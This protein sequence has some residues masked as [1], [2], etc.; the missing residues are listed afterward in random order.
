MTAWAIS[1]EQPPSWARGGSWCSPT[2]CLILPFCS[3][4]ACLLDHLAATRACSQ[5]SVTGRGMQEE[6]GRQDAALGCAVPQLPEA[7][8]MSSVLLRAYAAHWLG[9]VPE[10]AGAGAAPS[11]AAL[12]PRSMMR[13]PVGSRLPLPQVALDP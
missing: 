2:L 1:P 6:G 10:Q 4:V 9:L 5:L 7:A 3:C 11:A 12:R 13:Q 8:H